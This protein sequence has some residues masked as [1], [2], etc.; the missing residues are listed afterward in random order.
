MSSI[1]EE[2]DEEG[3][4]REVLDTDS[5]CQFEDDRNSQPE[6]VHT[7]SVTHTHIQVGVSLCV[8]VRLPTAEK[9]I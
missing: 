2:E 7:D 8:C 3:T 5:P 6:H 1:I 9:L 4:S